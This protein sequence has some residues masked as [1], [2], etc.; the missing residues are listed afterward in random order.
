MTEQLATKV[1]LVSTGIAI[2]VL[3]RVHD[4]A[5]TSRD[6]NEDVEQKSGSSVATLNVS[7]NMTW[8]SFVRKQHCRE[9]N[10]C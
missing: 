9:I 3:E 2:L 1:Q 6:G 10:C 5:E 7:T 4:E 8:I